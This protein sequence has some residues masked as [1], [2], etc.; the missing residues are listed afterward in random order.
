MNFDREPRPFAALAIGLVLVAAIAI[1]LGTIHQDLSLATPALLLVLPVLLTALTGGRGPSVVVALA[2][3]LAFTLGFIPPV[4]TLRVN[5][6]IDLLALVVFVAVATVVGGLVADQSERRRSAEE[7]AEQITRMH[8]ELV[9]ASAEAQKVA[10]LEEV[11]RHRAALLRSVSHDLRTP[12]V[13]IQG[14]ASDLRSD[15]VYHGETRAQLLDLVIDEAERLDRIVA[16]LLSMSRIDAGALEPRMQPIDIA[17]LIDTCVRRV[18]RLVAG[19]TL[20][21]DVPE[22]LPE[23]VGDSALLDQVLT[24]LLE[25]AVRHGGDSVD[26]RVRAEIGTGAVAVTVS[27]NGEGLDPE[28]QRRLFEPWNSGVTSSSSGVGL[29]ICKSILEAHGGT[30]RF[31]ENVVGVSF[32]FTLPVSGQ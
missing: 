15:D 3:A 18:R 17:E 4:L 7:T 32:T 25:N 23:V 1:P 5:H 27:D 24:N 14:V 9:R 10:V 21:L 19:T 11:D 2:A 31:R 16:N 26:V 30:I 22:F 13:T 28:V 20:E 6:G 12:L 29:A 8:E